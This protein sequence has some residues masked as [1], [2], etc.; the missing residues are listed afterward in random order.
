MAQLAEGDGSSRPYVPMGVTSVSLVL[1]TRR[2][3]RRSRCS[4]RR[5]P[6]CPNWNRL[7][8]SCSDA[9]APG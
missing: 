2:V 4:T 6:S 5:F 7:R 9:R 3:V 8:P 1:P